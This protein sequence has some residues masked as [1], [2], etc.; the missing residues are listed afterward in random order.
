MEPRAMFSWWLALEK[1]KWWQPTIGLSLGHL[2][3]AAE[4]NPI[5]E[6]DVGV[7][8]PFSIKSISP[9]RPTHLQISAT[10]HS[11]PSITLL[12]ILFSLPA[13][14][15]RPNCKFHQYGDGP[16]DDVSFVK[17]AHWFERDPWN[18]QI[19]LISLIYWWESCWTTFRWTSY[20]GCDDFF[21]TIFKSRRG[22]PLTNVDWDGSTCG[23]YDLRPK[24][25]AMVP[26]RILQ[27][28]D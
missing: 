15:V 5:T 1:T 24:K 16:W 25:N 2:I 8:G 14:I 4:D 6:I 23:S 11:F 12:N 26:S 28:E 3:S 19:L 17:E 27:F 9:L 22:S 18:I 10:S 13:P 7:E 20:N 21:F